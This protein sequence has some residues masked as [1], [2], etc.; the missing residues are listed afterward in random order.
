MKKNTS[1]LIAII[2]LALLIVGGIVFANNTNFLQ[3]RLSNVSPTRNTRV[4]QDINVNE[5]K[6]LNTSPTI[7]EL[8]M[9]DEVERCSSISNDRDRRQCFDTLKDVCLDEHSQEY[10]SD[11]V[12]GDSGSSD[13]DTSSDTSTETTTESSS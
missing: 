8:D 2:I 5:T 3:G 4:M 11:W 13:A 1:A 9:S 7:Q 10:C 12:P 6:L